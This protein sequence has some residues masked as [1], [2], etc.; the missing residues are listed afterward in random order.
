MLKNKITSS[1]IS[2]FGQ[3]NK[4][5]IHGD[6]NGHNVCIDKFVNIVILDWQTATFYGGSNL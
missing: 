2:K 3:K 1:L 5:F 4:S 6:F